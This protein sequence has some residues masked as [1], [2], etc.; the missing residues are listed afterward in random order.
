M[1]QKNVTSSPRPMPLLDN[2]GSRDAKKTTKRIKSGP[3]GFLR[4]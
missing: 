2:I 1:P 3:V 4:A